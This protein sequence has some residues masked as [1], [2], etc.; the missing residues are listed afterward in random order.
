[1]NTKRRIA[2]WIAALGLC[3]SMA[4]ALPASADYGVGGNGTAIMEYLDRGIYAVKS[5]SGTFVSWRWN[6][7]DPDDAEFR[8]YRDGKLIYT[9]KSGDP[10]CYQD[11]ATGG[12]YR[13]DCLSGGKVISSEECRFSSGTNYLD[14]KLNSPGAQ[15]SPNDFSV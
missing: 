9:G 13:V 14:I 11:N 4:P 7:N 10:T 15:Y 12:K 5:G 1:M 3:A 6:A 8:L 2:A